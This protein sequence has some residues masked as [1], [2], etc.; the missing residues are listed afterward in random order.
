MIRFKAKYKDI[1]HGNPN[2]N[3]DQRGCSY[4]KEIYMH[5]LRH[6]CGHL[7][8]LWKYLKAKYGKP[9]A[10]DIMKNLNPFIALGYKERLRGEPRSVGADASWEYLVDNHLDYGEDF[11]TY[12][13]IGGPA[14][15]YYYYPEKW[16]GWDERVKKWT[17]GD[18][19]LATKDFPMLIYKFGWS[20][21]EC[22]R[23][24]ENAIKEIGRPE[25][26]KFINTIYKAVE[27]HPETWGHIEIF[28]IVK[29]I[30]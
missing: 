24:L 11:R 10:L 2:V 4:P 16:D 8:F 18:P 25:C 13:T 12:F 3:P 30:L 19:A 26:Q 5:A 21:A 28:P 22:K 14:A 15:E 1:I 6:E 27:G 29:D 17:S 23:Q 20:P 7:W 9:K